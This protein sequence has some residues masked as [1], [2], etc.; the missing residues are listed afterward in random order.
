MRFK[1]SDKTSLAALALVCS[2]TFTATLLLAYERSQGSQLEDAL[3]DAKVR[4]SLLK[5]SNPDKK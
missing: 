4:F 1:V 3:E 2:G 5:P